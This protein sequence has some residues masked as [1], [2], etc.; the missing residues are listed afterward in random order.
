MRAR[1]DL[2]DVEDP[3][4]G[5]IRQQAPFPRF[6]GRPTPTPSGAPRLGAD[7]D[8]VWTGLVG[9]TTEELDHLRDTGVV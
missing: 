4:V 8:A 7:N 2:V 3:V 1:K 6:I 5:T 9:L